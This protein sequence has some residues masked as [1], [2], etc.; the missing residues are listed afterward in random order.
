MAWQDGHGVDLMIVDQL[1]DLFRLLLGV[2]NTDARSV[3]SFS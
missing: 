1:F 3:P 2:G